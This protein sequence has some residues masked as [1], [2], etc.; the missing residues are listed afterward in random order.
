VLFEGVPVVS[1]ILCV[2]LF[3]SVFATLLTGYPVAF[4]LA[5]TS[6]LVALL[7]ISL[8]VF[9]P[10][11]L[12]G[13]ALRYFGAVTNETLVAV[14]LF[15]FMGYVLEKSGIAE[16][17]LTTLGGLFGR[18]HGGLGFSVIFVGALL[19]ASTG[20]VGATV[21]T[22]GLI[23]LPAM[24]RAG[25]DNKLSIGL[26]A[27]SATLSQIIPPSTV[28]I[29]VGDLLTSINQ[30]AQMRKGNFSPD[31]ISV[32]DLFAGALIP[33]LM[34]A[35][36]YALWLGIV[37]IARPQHCPPIEVKDVSG[38]Q[39]VIDVLGSL[40]PPLALIACV[41]GSILTGLATATESASIGAIGALFLCATRRRLSWKS[42]RTACHDTLITSAMIF[43]VV[44]AASAFS[45]VFREL[46]GEELIGGILAQMPGG[47]S[48]ALAVVMAVIFFLGFV[49]DT[50]EIVLIVLPACGPALL[51]MGVEPIWLGVLIGINLQT[52]YLTPPF[53][54]ALFY[55]R[56]VVPA[57]IPTTDIWRAAAPWVAIQVVALVIVWNFSELA[58]WLPK[59]LFASGA[60]ADP[61]ASVVPSSGGLLDKGL[62]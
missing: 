47:A 7:G 58:T 20:V 27:S 38:L 10:V 8:G 39:R 24:Q 14:P 11:V 55:M 43:A 61:G 37:A 52:S 29:V 1:A 19:A 4:S 42:L 46:R 40:V 2:V 30:T 41:L 31:P 36:L 33:G 35:G 22:M 51:A 48:G 17:L 18:L 62:Y 53:G 57:S 16:Q 45:L 60:V 21:V 13:L 9:D 26:I 50:F 12:S 23:S 28:L 5:G 54:Y 44:L 3:A 6:I 49:L 56:R 25:Y 15:V 59:V 34:L 32:G